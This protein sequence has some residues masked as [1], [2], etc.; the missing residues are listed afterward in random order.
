M[1]RG[2]I[3]ILFILMAY[4]LSAEYDALGNLIE[5]EEAE[6][7]LIEESEDLPPMFFFGSQE[8]VKIYS[9][10][11]QSI[12]NS[13]ICKSL[14]LDELIQLSRGK[15]NQHIININLSIPRVKQM[16]DEACL[17]RPGDYVLALMEGQQKAVEMQGFYI[18]RD[19]ASCFESSP[20]SLWA[21]VQEALPSSLLLYSTNLDFPEGANLYRPFTDI[22]L[23]SIDNNLR[24]HLG[25]VVRFLDD[26]DIKVY[27]VDGPNCKK[28]AHLSR[29]KVELD[30]NDLPNEILL[31]SQ[32]DEFHEFWIEKVDQRFGSGHIELTGIWDY[33]ADGLLDLLI[34][35]DHRN[36]PYVILF[37]GME[38]GF[39]V[40]ELPNEP[41]GC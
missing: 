41:C 5:N 9:R 29:K 33:N 36:C 26:F 19:A 21:R 39:E 31:W 1:R 34:Q 35:G 40:Q 13:W 20:Y 12:E 14:E 4:R 24:A 25:S 3:I 6:S 23:M 10:G 17:V 28:I 2:G 32:D 22:S 8:G 27:P 38:K 7:S 18:K 16:F 37:Q 11:T 15:P 30:D